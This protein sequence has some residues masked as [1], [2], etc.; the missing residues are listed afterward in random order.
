MMVWVSPVCLEDVLQLSRIGPAN[1]KNNISVDD[2]THHREITFLSPVG[3]AF[4]DCF[5]LK[6]KSGQAIAGQYEDGDRR[7]FHAS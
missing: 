6:W 2:A 4:F 7:F 1:H 5:L 3:F